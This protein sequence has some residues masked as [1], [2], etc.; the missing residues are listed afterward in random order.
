MYVHKLKEC[1]QLKGSHAI[2]SKI[3]L[4]QKEKFVKP[5]GEGVE[6]MIE[7]IRGMRIKGRCFNSEANLVLFP[8]DK[9]R[10][11]IV[12]GKNG[13]GKSTLS[14]GISCIS[15]N[16]FPEDLTAELID[17]EGNSIYISGTEPIFV[18]NEKYIDK[19]IKIDDD[20]LGA[21][22]L[23]GE[24]VDLQA[25]IDRVSSIVETLEKEC[26]AANTAF[27]NYN[28]TGNPLNPSYHWARIGVILRQPGGW[29]EIDS[30]IKCNRRNSSVTDD[31]V[32][33]I[34][35]LNVK[36]SSAHLQSVFD[37]KQELLSKVSD[38]SITYPNKINLI[39]YD[40]QLEKRT[41][42]LLGE[43]ID[44]PILSAREKMILDTIQNGGQ[45]NI[46]NA[47]QDFSDENTLFC[48]YCYQEISETYRTSLV[49]SINK[50]L[51]KDVDLHK[52]ALNG[53]VFPDIICDV[54][55]YEPIDGILVKSIL[56]QSAKC[57]TIVEQYK[58]LIQEKEN[59]VYTPL[60]ANEYGLIKE[61]KKLNELL[62]KLDEKRTEFNLAATKKRALTN[63]LIFINKQIAHHQTVQIYKDYLK[64]DKEKSN[65]RNNLLKKQAQLE[66]EKEKLKN[67]QDRK[68]NAGLA[69]SSI[70][71]ALD[72]VF[73]SKGRL[74]IELK[75]DKYYLNSNGSPVK[76]K[77]IS[78]GERNIIALC[79]FF[80][81]IMNNQEISK[82]YMNESLV[83]I[84]DPV[85]S[86]DFENKVGII[87]FLKYQINRIIK[88][89]PNSKVLVLSHDLETVINLRKA[90]EEISQ[91]T[92]GIAKID[93]S[94][95]YVHELIN[96][97]LKQLAKRN[98]YN[99]L[100]RQ[101]YHFANGEQDTDP[102]VIGNAMRRVLEAFS[103]FN[104]RKG[105]EQVS[106]D[107][108][109]L[110]S[111]GN[112]STYFEN[113]M[114]RL[115]LHGE[116]HYEDQVYSL[117]DGNNFFEFI[118]LEEK[119]KTARNVLCF[120]YMLSP[121]HLIS[122]LQ[123]E[124]KALSNIREWVNHIPEN[125]SFEIKDLPTKRTIHLYD[126]PLS[127]GPGNDILEG[128]PYEDYE[129]DNTVC[130]FALKISG[131]SME[132]RIKDRSIVLVK[133]ASTLDEKKVGA[134]FL[135][136]RGYCKILS[137]QD[138]KTSLCSYNK[139]YD[140]IQIEESD[141][142]ITFG[143]VIEIIEPEQR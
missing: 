38:V 74:S 25:E 119:K 91:S 41:I 18:F 57:Q 35:S 17:A 30:K 15:K 63:E 28:E 96:S 23:L 140:P 22:I 5:I 21:I 2:I 123:D 100:L 118:S 10:I 76:P 26:D 88:G 127:A 84:D 110:E 61:I 13:S 80:T 93:H 92:K 132:P 79:Y 71:N 69:I 55:N 81:Q 98:E 20:G 141:C 39:S 125:K 45:K 121:Y 128:V 59:N 54:E 50:V 120:M 101:V 137:Y 103:T 11:S 46:E 73:F 105:I 14:E 67:L 3:Q 78:I 47:R 85:S 86:F 83:A 102:V 122:H 29:A 65:V 90:V 36:D 82:L 34:C 107:R 52:N 12:Y 4:I 95:Y 8:N 94:T 135:N 16:S 104:Y 143:E 48:P 66:A 58:R 72:Y 89:N 42:K 40:E 37:E 99:V 109:V 9:D 51:N 112:H 44:K 136:G 6:S 56:K 111:L 7:Q 114:Y 139:A 1:F 142:I 130:D 129:T 31:I 134:F 115:V 131:D 60:T 24:Q 124:S 68:S 116:S 133:K 53:V 126:M 75:N 64:Q 97:S 33:E 106:C 70:N 49:A 32:N 27:A 108:N 117:H 43:Q 138:G 77:N 62:A 19:N 87:S 113:L